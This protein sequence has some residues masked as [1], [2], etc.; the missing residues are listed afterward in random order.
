M[1]KLQKYVLT[2]AFLLILL[3][4][5]I[6]SA[7]AL[8][9]KVNG[10][11]LSF[12]ASDGQ[13]FIEDGRT[14]VP[15]RKA[16]ESYGAEVNWDAQT[17]TARISKDGVTVEVPI[18]SKYVYLNGVAIENDVAAKIVDSRT[19]L[20]IRIVLESLGATVNWDSR[21][22]MVLIE[23][24]MRMRMKQA[25]AAYGSS[26]WNLFQQGYKYAQAENFPMA[27][28]CFL[29]ASE[30]WD[31]VP[32][33]EQ[34][35]LYA[36]NLAMAANADARLYLKTS[37]P[38]YDT[39]RYFGAPNEPQN[40]ILL[41]STYNS[42]INELSGFT[43]GLELQYFSYGTEFSKIGEWYYGPARQSGMVLQMAWQPMD[44]VGMVTDRDYLIRQAKYLE[45]TGCRILLRFANEMNDETSAWYTADYN[46]YI[47]KFRLVADI[48][49]QYAPSVGIVWAPN[50]YPANTV[51][52]YYPGDEY[53][54]YVG[55]SVYQEYNP[56]ND[57]L[58]Y[59]IER[60]RWSDILDQVYATYGSRKPIII[61]EGGCSTISPWVSGDL[62]DFAVQ[63]M[64]LFYTYLPIKYPNVKMAVLFNSED[65]GGREFR[66]SKSDALRNAYASTIQKSGRY[67]SKST[68]KA[69]SEYYYELYPN[70]SVPAGQVTLC[71]YITSPL[72]DYTQVVYTVNGKTYTATD[73]PYPVTVDCAGLSG[74]TITVRVQAYSGSALRVD[75]SFQI[76]VS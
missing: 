13:P 26:A 39:T 29:R 74:Q 35:T 21:N 3:S 28:A 52:L 33:Q 58:N 70:Y 64:K 22:S 49:H 53:V 5:M 50:F 73:M 45:S 44:G 31:G 66:L 19:Y 67:L 48:F 56:D 7:G 36:Y 8:G 23:D 17:K 62:T 40:G 30:L 68:Q 72:M 51:D 76:R 61:S 18:G 38:A 75:K 1:K 12:S 43:H 32:G 41:G 54:D 4:A 25:E 14:L 42:K 15:L 46:L 63:Q 2:F 71:S 37:D 20:P 27:T 60:G 16:A 47:E 59:G 10:Q 34:M 55:L 9:V 6:C 11:T 24:P 65:W 57:P 69:A